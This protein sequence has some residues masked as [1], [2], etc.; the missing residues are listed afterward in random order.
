[1]ADLALSTG[2]RQLLMS[3][4]ALCGNP[5]VDRQ[6][7]IRVA[8]AVGDD[9][10][11]RLRLNADAVPASDL[12]WLLHQQ[13]WPGA[14]TADSTDRLAPVAV[15][16]TTLGAKQ[17][18]RMAARLESVGAVIRRLMP[19]GEVPPWFGRR[20]VVICRP[21]TRSLILSVAPNLPERQVLV[22]P[23]MNSDRDLAVIIRQANAVLPKTQG[24]RSLA[25]ERDIATTLWDPDVYSLGVYETREAAFLTSAPTSSLYRLAKRG[26]LN[27]RHE[28]ITLWSFSDLVAVRTWQYLR[29]TSAKRV[30]PD[31]VPALSRFAGDAHAIKVGATSQGRVFVD[32]G[33]G[34]IDIQTGEQLLDIPIADVDDAFRPFSFGGRTAPDLLHASDHTRLH[35]AVLHGSPHLRRHR[36]SAVALAKL[37][38]RGGR[39]AILSAYP[40]LK[41]VAISDT[42]AV[43]HQLAGVR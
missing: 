24:L 22:D 21:Q 6:T 31:V 23:R 28:G 12:E 14:S 43:G 41:E 19:E 39:D 8:E 40:E 2:D 37:D 18:L 36:I 30:T 1:V 17:V 3:A 35:P 10:A 4:A 20:T 32:R 9:P 11:G 33:E 7:R 26:L 13:R 27:P 34:W 25:Y 15:I 29:A 16:D 5:A 38:D 42:V